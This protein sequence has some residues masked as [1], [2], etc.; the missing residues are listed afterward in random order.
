M[1]TV[2]AFA[3]CVAVLC[4]VANVYADLLHDTEHLEPSDYTLREHSLQKPFLSH[5]AV[6]PFWDFNGNS[7]VS[8]EFVRLTPDRQTKRGG[9]WNSRAYNRNNGFEMTVQFKVHGQG[10]TLAGDGFALWYAREPLTQGS[11]FGS[12][13]KFEGLAIFFDT[14]SNKGSHGYPYVSY[15]INNGKHEY[16]HDFDGEHPDLETSG[17]QA[18]FRN[19]DYHTHA[20]VTYRERILKVELDVK[21]QGQWESCF[22]AFDVDLPAGYFF[23]ATAATGDLADNHDILS[24][25]VSEPPPLS[26]EELDEMAKA[27]NQEV[28]EEEE[29]NE[30]A[31]PSK[32]VKQ[33][34]FRGGN[35]A[36]KEESGGGFMTYV[37]WIIVAAVLVVVGFVVKSKMG[38][39]KEARFN[40]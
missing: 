28:N 32:P 10:K 34:T 17:C 21:N 11:V 2:I 37:I 7:V 5:G 4:S 22:F 24:I 25:K 39:S 35:T 6:M 15:M 12:K 1:Q 8:D 3:A 29:K 9:I 30:E 13:D 31:P 20:R 16:A 19:Q 26:A 23:G 38:P 36:Q 33:A 18:S 27:H 14:Y 40:F